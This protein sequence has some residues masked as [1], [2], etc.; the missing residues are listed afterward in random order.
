MPLSDPA[1]LRKA[2]LLA[3]LDE[4]EMNTLAQQTD[5]RKLLAGQTLFAMGDPGGA[6][7]LVLDGTIELFQPQENGEK[8]MLK[9]AEPGEMFGE[10]SLLDNQPRSANARALEDSELL[11]LDRND[12][13]ILFKRHPESAF[14]I[15]ALLTKRVRETTDL[16]ARA[17][18]PNPNEVTEAIEM[19]ATTAERIADWLTH[20]ASSIPFAYGNAL[21]FFV[22]IVLNTSIIPGLRPFDPFPFGLLTM[23]V[24]LEAIFLSLFVLISQ[25]RQAARDQIRNDIEYEVNIRAEQEIRIMNRRLDEFEQ[26]TLLHLARLSGLDQFPLSAGKTEK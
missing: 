8:L 1:I 9:I 6:M 26:S 22:W 3:L 5:I 10:L 21:L 25:S 18:I 12:L 13:E 16:Y 24:S 14:D 20:M 4:Q 23:A 17:A 15:I 19:H 7:Y 2:Q 11:V